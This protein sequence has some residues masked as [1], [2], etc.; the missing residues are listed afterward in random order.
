MRPEDQMFYHLIAAVAEKDF[1]FQNCK[2]VLLFYTENV[3]I[4]SFLVIL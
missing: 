2:N 3:Y 1:K 4:N